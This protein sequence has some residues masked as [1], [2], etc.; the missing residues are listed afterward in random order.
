MQRTFVNSP[1]GKLLRPRQTLRASPFTSA[2]AVVIFDL[3]KFPGPEPPHE[4]AGTY[5]LSL[6]IATKTRSST[7]AVGVNTVELFASV[8]AICFARPAID[9][10]ASFAEFAGVSPGSSEIRVVFGVQ[11]DAPRHVSRTNT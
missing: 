9:G 3:Q 8:K 2:L 6:G 5:W 11:F 4:A 10:P 7:G 1:S